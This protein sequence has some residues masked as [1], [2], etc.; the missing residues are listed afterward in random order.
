MHEKCMQG[1]QEVFGE[2]TMT[3]TWVAEEAEREVSLSVPAVLWGS[4]GWRLLMA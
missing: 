3:S 2:V 4:S 1:N